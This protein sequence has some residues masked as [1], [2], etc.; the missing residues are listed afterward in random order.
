MNM[1]TRTLGSAIAV[2]LV[3]GTAY[4]VGC[5]GGHGAAGH[6]EDETA[7]KADS[8]ALDKGHT[9][10]GFNVRHMGITNVRG[11]FGEYDGEI[12]IRG[13]DIETLKV[14]ATI[15]AA[16]IDTNNQRRDN[17]LRNPDFFEVETWPEI[18][19]RSKRVV[20]H[21]DGYALVGDMTMK[22]VTKEVKLPVII[23]GP[24]EDPWGGSRLGLEIKG[25]VNRHDFGVGFDGVSDR[26]IGNDVQFDIHVQAIKQ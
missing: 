2:V 1:R 6:G 21:E 17:H 24:V 4:A 10:V 25:S 11:L 16:S 3:S 20:S 15:Q 13:D 14:K 23:S 12:N 26:M 5:C 19:F 9:T 22:D 7:A 8:Y 18:I